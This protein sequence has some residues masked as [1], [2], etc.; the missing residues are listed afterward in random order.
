MLPK[1]YCRSAF[2]A[3]VVV[4]QMSLPGA[5][6]ADD[7]APVFELDCINFAGRGLANAPVKKKK[8]HPG[9]AVDGTLW[10]ISPDTK[11]VV[12]TKVFAGEP[13]EK[14][15]I[16]TGDEI[17]SVNGYPTEG[18]SV[19]E[20]FFAYHMFDLDNQNETL[21]VQKKDGTKNTVK[22]PVLTGQLAN[23]E[24]KKG[25]QEKYK[26]MGYEVRESK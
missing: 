5:V 8:P 24:E 18:K 6:R 26:D 14:A 19:R 11:R 17:I 1:I 21:V 25:W 22:V 7:N 15:G 3:V 9:L 4:M 20:I 13:A 10:D 12:V 2:A 16:T 23:E